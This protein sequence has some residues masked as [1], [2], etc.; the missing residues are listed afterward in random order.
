MENGSLVV[1]VHGWNSHPGIWKRLCV[2]L[3]EAGIPY[4]SFDHA[5]MAGEP[6]PAIAAALGEFL[7]GVEEEAGGTA[8][9]DLVCH[10]VGTCIARYLVEVTDGGER[11][12]R[13][14]QLIG[15]GPPNRGS[16]L[17][18]LF[19]H[20]EYGP[21]I[22]DRLTGTFVPEGFD[23]VRDPVVQDV[24]PESPVMRALHDAGIRPDIRYRV[25]VTANPEG[26][27]SFFPLLS[28]RTYDLDSSGNLRMTWEG[29]GIV[30]HRDSA[31]PGVS[32]DV[33]PAG[34]GD[35]GT[36]PPPDQF[37]HISLPKN[38]VVIDRVIRYLRENPGEEG[39]AG[40]KDQ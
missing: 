27:T 8:G 13:I 36:L 12:F 14:R 15:L 16:A 29:D 5:G 18:E 9:I 32:L 7:E 11:R 2:R 39:T 40:K 24:R 4:R 33:L 26:S 31:L 10:S 21:G 3:N 37:C 1:L 19:S 22:I 25:I 34:N 20:P 35:A 38:P 23:P 28:G 30:A 6:L 17:A